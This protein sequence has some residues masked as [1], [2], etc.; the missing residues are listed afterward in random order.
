MQVTFQHTLEISGQETVLRVT[1]TYF[2]NR[3]ETRED[4]AENESIEISEVLDSAND[5]LHLISDEQV[6]ILES[7]VMAHVEQHYETYYEN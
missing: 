2:P 1:A 6:E 3:M 4:P 7:E 5:I